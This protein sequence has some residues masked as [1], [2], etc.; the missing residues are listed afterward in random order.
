MLRTTKPIGS[1]HST[2]FLSKSEEAL[3]VSSCRVCG[4]TIVALLSVGIVSPLYAQNAPES[5]I[6]SQTQNPSQSQSSADA[7]SKP[8]V[9]KTWTD[10][11]IKSLRP[12]SD[13]YEASVNQKS[14][15]SA[16]PAQEKVSSGGATSSQQTTE[17]SG[18]K[19]PDNADAVEQLIQK[20]EQDIRRKESVLDKASADMASAESDLEKSQLKSTV[21]IS[22]TDLEVSNN[23]LKLL[24][25]RLAQLKSN[26]PPAAHPDKTPDETP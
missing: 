26:P 7:K 12:L 14:A 16:A 19:L 22:K 10:D 2:R 6:Q 3:I 24:Q 1:C 18:L 17:T 15:T 5:A 21:E 8:K 4:W 11:N 23:D 13:Q 25:A 9:H 20:T